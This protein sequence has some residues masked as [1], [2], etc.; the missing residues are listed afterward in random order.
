M[1]VGEGRLDQAVGELVTCRY[2]LAE[3]ARQGDPAAL[4]ILGDLL[5]WAA[6]GAR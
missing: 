2:R 3:P 1:V 4:A 6:G 5:G